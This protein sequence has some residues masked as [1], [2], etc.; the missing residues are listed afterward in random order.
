MIK[1]ELKVGW[2]KNLRLYIFVIILRFIDIITTVMMFN[3]CDETIEAN[4]LMRFLLQ[5]P[6]LCLLI[7]ILFLLAVGYVCIIKLN[8]TK[9]RIKISK[10]TLIIMI[11]ISL[12]IIINNVFFLLLIISV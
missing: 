4:I 7:Q 5:I 6:P 10:Y 1:N 2:I 11:I 8:D 9:E 12:I 3:M